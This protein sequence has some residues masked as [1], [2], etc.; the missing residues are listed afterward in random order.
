MVFADL[1][2]NAQ[3][4]ET[5]LQMIEKKKFPN[6]LLFSGPEGVGK[7]HFAERFAKALMGGALSDTHHYRTE[8]KSGMHSIA[9]MQQLIE[10]VYMPPFESPYKVF[11]IHDAERMLP[12]SSNALLKTLEEP[13]PD[14][15]IILLTNEPQNL[16]P[17]IS[18]RC[19]HIP[20]Y[21]IPEKEIATW[22]QSSLAKSPEEAAK[23]A[24]LAQG[25]LSKAEQYAAAAK[26]WELPLI[27]FLSSHAEEERTTS[28]AKIEAFFSALKEAQ[29]E[30]DSFLI[31]IKEI[32][33]LF[34]HI[35]FW[36]R[37][38]HLL[39]QALPLSRLF[40]QE[41]IE[42]LKT[43]SLHP[44]PSMESVV[45]LIQECREAAQFHIKLKN[46]LEYFLLKV[47]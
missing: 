41:H 21:P 19:S 26:E 43:S 38:L 32:D 9:S 6:T 47:Q 44:L 7:A 28:L 36:Y 37:D 16:L 12:T 33:L 27:H 10:E 14:A 31:W 25:S 13:T 15:I 22:V 30:E 8:G 11:I 39:Q 17:T 34:E 20:F 40:Y 45:D 24:L 4:K 2:G 46:I 29:E 18:S 3:A 23:I 42:R 35:L 1:M 5:L